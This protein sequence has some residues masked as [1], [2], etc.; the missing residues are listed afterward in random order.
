MVVVGDLRL[1]TEICKKLVKETKAGEELNTRN[2]FP[3][4]NG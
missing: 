4:N 3:K 1:L 2:S